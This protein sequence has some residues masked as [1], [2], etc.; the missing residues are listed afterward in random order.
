L[1][2][3][4]WWFSLCRA[5]A[6]LFV[7]AGV[8]VGIV[9]LPTKAPHGACVLLFPSACIPGCSMNGA[10][11]CHSDKINRADSPSPHLPSPPSEI[12]TTISTTISTTICTAL[13]LPSYHRGAQTAFILFST[14]L[15]LRPVSAANELQTSINGR[16]E[17]RI[18]KSKTPV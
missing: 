1:G 16:L 5:A 4:V 17:I 18:F 14:F 7:S 3:G 13:T 15:D 9:P 11:P 2:L 8:D 12:P 10:D 6:G